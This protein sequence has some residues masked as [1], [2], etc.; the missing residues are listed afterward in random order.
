MHRGEI[1]WLPQGR[2][3]HTPAYT[4]C[5][6]IKDI[7]YFTQI[8]FEIRT[9]T[10]TNSLAAPGP[11]ANPVPTPAYNTHLDNDDGSLLFHRWT[12]GYLPLE[13]IE[14]PSCPMVA[15]LQNHWKTIDTNGGFQTLHLL[16]NPSLFEIFFVEKGLASCSLISS[17]F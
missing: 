1:H 8:R 6:L 15:G 12:N 10:F 13:T 7:W 17:A 11:W 3:A 16:A 9:N 4:F 2:A 5:D 14:K